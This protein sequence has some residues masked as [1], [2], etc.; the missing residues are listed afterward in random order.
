MVSDKDTLYIK[1][2]TLDEIH[3]FL[4]LIFVIWDR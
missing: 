1:I 3:I 4:V 2:I